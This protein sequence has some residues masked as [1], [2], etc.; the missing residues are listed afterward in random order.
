MNKKNFSDMSKE[1]RQ[2]IVWEMSDED[3]DFSDIPEINEDFFKTAK[4]IEHP[5]KSKTDNVRIKS[6]L[7]NWFKSH[8]QE[9][10]YEVLINNVLE[11]YI[12][13]QTEN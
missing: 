4:R 1:E 12:H 11:N 10:S 2:K 9:N 13:H 8:A 7:I 6:D 3:I 5:R